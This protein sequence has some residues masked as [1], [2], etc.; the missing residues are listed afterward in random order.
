MTEPA[1]SEQALA[2]PLR[3]A[4]LLM[5]LPFLGLLMFA[6]AAGLGLRAFSHNNSLSCELSC[7]HYSYA[8]P[9]GLGVL[10]VIVLMGGGMVASYYTARHIGL[11]LVASL[12]QRSRRP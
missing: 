7:S 8:L 1:P 12:R 9:I 6:I 4:F 11:P 10:G 5:A 3:R 2:R